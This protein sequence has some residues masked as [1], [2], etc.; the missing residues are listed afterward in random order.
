MAIS[1]AQ[2]AGIGISGGLGGAATGAAL[3]SIVPGIG[4]LIG[5]GLGGLL[6]SAGSTL[7]A[8]KTTNQLQ[9]EA[10]QQALSQ[11]G[12]Q[13]GSAGFIPSGQPGS[14]WG[15]SPAGVETFNLYTPQQQ[16]AFNQVLQQALGGLGKNQFD[17]APIESQARRGFSEQTIP[18]IAERFSR[19]GA[20]KSSAFGQQLGAAGAGL[21]SDLAAMKQQYG[22]KQQQMLQNLLGI[23][24]KPQFES[25]Y[26][27]GSEG[28]GR[29][30]LQSLLGQ[31]A[32][33]E[34]VAGAFGAAKGLF[35][36][37][38]RPQEPLDYT[39]AQQQAP[40][41]YAPSPTSMVG[42]TQAIYNPG[43]IVGG[44]QAPMA[45]YV[46]QVSPTGAIGNVQALR[47]LYGI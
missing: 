47:G 30:A 9:K 15:G 32:T 44:I 14:F 27:P 46:P 45:P 19:L 38:G 11:V 40:F 34:N 8:P 37:P 33:G 3:G 6:G 24:L 5:A 26:R 36:R 28:F 41:T 21:E 42:S 29:S 1:R 31:L 43:N 18:G 35:N 7:A 2:K 10:K 4:T 13:G 22:L 17:F 25:L 12:Q 23:G 20:Q 16:A 39:A